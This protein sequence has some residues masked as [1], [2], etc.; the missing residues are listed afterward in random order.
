M[1]HHDGSGST[2]RCRDAQHLDERSAYLVREVLVELIGIRATDVVGLD[3]RVEVSHLATLSVKI[4]Y[5]VYPS[6]GSTESTDCS[7]RR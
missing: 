2:I 1:S 7:I 3:D 6:Y 5:S 4:G